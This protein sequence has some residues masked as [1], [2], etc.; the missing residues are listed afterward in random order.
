MFILSAGMPKSS[1]TL[2]S[3]YQKNILEFTVPNNGQKEFERMIRDGEIKGVGAFVHDLELPGTQE[4]LV[5]LSESI[6]PFVVKSHLSLTNDLARHLKEKQIL[7]TYIHRDPRDVI[8][9]AMDHGKRPVDHPTM[10]SY[11]LQFDSVQ[12]SVPL[13]REF[14]KTG[15]EWVQSGL[16]EIFRYDDLMIDPEKELSR[17]CKLIEVG[18]DVAYIRE[19]ISNF[20][21]TTKKWKRQFNTGK[22]LRY[23]D[24]MSPQEIEMCNR[25]LSEELRI[26]G[27]T[28]S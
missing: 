1:S 2:L 13:V 16:C 6:G 15:I 23:A 12:N 19:L 7:A 25:E 28:A 22:L 20:T 27:Y 4:K 24:E 26:F 10:N 14:C 8:L 17:F 21:D 3:L 18:V 5:R 9:S 11:F